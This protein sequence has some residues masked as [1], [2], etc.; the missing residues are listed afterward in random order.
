MPFWQMVLRPTQNKAELPWVI[1]LHVLQS[2]FTD[3]QDEI[4]ENVGS[5]AVALRR[6]NGRFTQIP[7]QYEQERS[8]LL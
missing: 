2:L 1:V 8:L 7:K 6:F 5:P 3:R 4:K